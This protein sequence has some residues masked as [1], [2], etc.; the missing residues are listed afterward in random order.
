M[1]QTEK[2]TRLARLL[3]SSPNAVYEELKEYGAEVR[4]SPYAAPSDELES[5]LAGRNDP[6]IDLALASYGS[7]EDEIGRL[8]KNAKQPPIDATDASYK[9]GVRLAVLANETVA[10]KSILNQFPE[11]VIGEAELAYVLKDADWSEAQT[12]IE[13]PTISADVLKALYRGD[14]I[15]EGI[16]EKRRMQLVAISGRNERVHTCKDDEY[17]PDFTSRDIHKAIFEMLETVPTSSNWL[18]NL[19][20]LLEQ[21]DPDQ[22]QTPDS[23]DAVLG[24]WSVDEKGEPDEPSDREPY[25]DTGLPERTDFRCLIAALYG[26]S[27]SSDGF[28]IHGSPDDEDVAR[29][30]AYYGNAQLDVKAIKEGYERDGAT[31]AFAA[32]LNDSV[33]LNRRSRKLFED[34]CMTGRHLHRYRRRCDQLHKRWPSFDPRPTAEWMIEEAPKTEGL[35]VRLQEQVSSLADRLS[36]VEKKVAL[37]PWLLVGLAL[38]IVWR[39]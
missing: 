10:S 14:K 2:R 8:Y 21:V 34:E 16:D 6:L 24:R 37:L 20:Y 7:S 26:R 18:S 39:R 17:G 29:R 1:G 4:A 27:W 3:I 19:R 28:V 13:N 32:M 9:Q 36:A 23:L 38:L 12:L 5:K 30:C 31:F 22:V 35:D 33:L 25:T 11:N 15:A